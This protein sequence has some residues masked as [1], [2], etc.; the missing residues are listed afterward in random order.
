MNLPASLMTSLS[1]IN[2]FDRDAFVQVHE[3]G[4]QVVSVRL[5][6]LKPSIVNGEWSIYNQQSATHHLSFI[7]HQPVP[8][9]SSGYYLGERPSF[10]LDPLL[11]AGAYYVQEASS[12]FLEQALKQSVELD[13]PLLVLDLCAAPGGK[14]T[15][16][17]SVISKESLLV[18][19]EVIQTRVN[20]L[21]EN[22]IK[23]GA[24]NVVVT[25]ND[26]TAF[27]KLHGLFDVVVIDAPCSGSGL[28][29]RDAEA[30]KEWS[31]DNVQLCSQRQ[32]RILADAWNC[33]KEDG[34]LIYS[35]CSYSSEEDEEILDWITSNYK[36]E[37]KKL[38]VEEKWNIDE[39]Q[40]TAGAYGYRFWPYKVKGEGFFIAAFKKKE[41]AD[42]L[43]I[44]IK[45]TQLPSKQEATI[46]ANW[47]K[48]TDGL[49]FIKQGQNIA[50]IPT[51]WNETIQY[52]MQELKVR[53]AGVEMGTIAKNDLLPEHALALS[54]MISD[55]VI[56]VEL[57]KEQALDY[58][59][60]NE[61]TI[62]IPHKGWA[63]ATYNEHPLGWMKLLG[64]RI[65]N[66]Y[67]KEWRIL[68]R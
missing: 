66:Y 54:T 22:I 61:I 60:K 3:S 57:T 15:L 35:T 14:S 67:P 40:S 56:R 4:E 12:M 18:S 43:R 65:N 59:R 51:Q 31:E 36:V 24:G 28:F 52:L 63:L 21:K 64:N 1:K 11:H 13:Q 17:Q 45:T 68:M 46:A 2:S 6:P 42:Q 7:T 39:V 26:P 34:V 53:Y 33:L 41:P 5:N 10:T 19:N 23:W 32:Q 48:H 16:L 47:L 8:W 38:K 62:E 37:S 27:S 44:K 50:T 49:T 30:I 55:S 25:N 20:I 9:S 58:L 29:R